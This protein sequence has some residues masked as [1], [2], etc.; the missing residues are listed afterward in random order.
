[1]FADLA[2][3][4]ASADLGQ[5]RTWRQAPSS[6]SMP[7]GVA[8]MGLSLVEDNSAM[9]DAVQPRPGDNSV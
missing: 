8:F 9:R 2:V 5:T 4:F 3:N 7:V 1:M 6:P